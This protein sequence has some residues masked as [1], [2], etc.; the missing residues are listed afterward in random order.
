MPEAAPKVSVCITTY[1]H[2]PYIAQALDGVLAQ[3]TNFEFEILIGEDCS[4]DQTRKIVQEYADRHPGKIRL[5]LHSGDDKIQIG[6]VITGRRNFVNNLDEARGEYVALLEGDD[7]WTDPQKLQ[8]QVDALD[9]NPECS[10]AFHNAEV[11]DD[12]SGA[13][14]LFGDL[15]GHQI[16]SAETVLSGWKVPTASILYRCSM[17]GPLPDWFY[18][19]LSGDYSLQMLLVDRGPFIYLDR[20]MSV[21]RQHAG[22][23][24]RYTGDLWFH[25]NLSSVYRNFDR[26]TG[27]R[28]QNVIGPILA[29]RYAESSDMGRTGNNNPFQCF[30]DEILSLNYRYHSGA[31]SLL[32]Y[33][34]G[35]VRWKLQAFKGGLAKVG[36]KL[37]LA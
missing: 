36:R 5:F 34:L 27:H 29:E 21:Y 19:V 1:N 26:Q 4:S 25:R 20:V 3:Q 10:L 30:H 16:V 33:P 6:P 31:I 24:S 23:I 13:R 32:E 17:L 35:V 12:L 8:L 11:L 18:T 28:Y 22:G 9:A 14:E 7:Y 37:K 2:E 15:S